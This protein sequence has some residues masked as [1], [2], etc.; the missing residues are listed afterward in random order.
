ML[1]VFGSTASGQADSEPTDILVLP[2]DAPLAISRLLADWTALLGATPPSAPRLRKLVPAS[3]TS[4]LLAG[5]GLAGSGRKPAELVWLDTA[6][7]PGWPFQ[8]PVA[9][10][11]VRRIFPAHSAARTVED[12]KAVIE[13]RMPHYVELTEWSNG[14]DGEAHGRLAL[15]VTGD[16]G[17]IE[18]LVLWERIADR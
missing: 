17:R 16:G 15:P 10:Q 13:T 3:E 14:Q 7:A 4:C 8:A 11:P 5:I 1:N 2:P 18:L 9:G 12:L 6:A